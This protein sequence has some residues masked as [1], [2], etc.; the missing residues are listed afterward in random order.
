MYQKSALFFGVVILILIGVLVL[1]PAPPPEFDRAEGVKVSVGSGEVLVKNGE[2]ERRLKTGEGVLAYKSGD[3]IDLTQ[4]ENS[5][6][7]ELP[8]AIS[9]D[10]AGATA[11]DP[12]RDVT[13]PA[14][15]PGNEKLWIVGYSQT[16][17]GKPL[18]NTGIIVRVRPSDPPVKT[19]TDGQGY[20][21]V[22]VERYKRYSMMAI[23][24]EN[25]SI[26]MAAVDTGNATDAIVQNFY[27]KATVGGVRGQ[28]VDKETREPVA[29]ARIS[30][31][32]D[33][34]QRPELEKMKMGL[35]PRAI[36]DAE[37]KFEVWHLPAGNYRLE[38]EAKGY[39]YFSPKKW[40][41]DPSPLGSI[42]VSA[43]SIIED[44][45]VKLEAGGLLKV[46]V[47]DAKGQ[48]VQMARI[49]VIVDENRTT[50][51]T[52]D[53]KGEWKT[54][55]IAKGNVIV[56][57]KKDGFGESW[58]DVVKTGTVDAPAEVEIV[59]KK[60]GRVSGRVMMKDGSAGSD[61]RLILYN[62]SVQSMMGLV[63]PRQTA[64]TTTAE[65][66][67]YS[68]GDLGEGEY[69]ILV[70]P[71]I[72]GGYSRADSV[73]EKAIHLAEGQNLENVDFLIDDDLPNEKVTGIVVDQDEQPIEDVHVF[74]MVQDRQ[75]G[76]DKTGENGSDWT[77]EKGEFEISGLKKAGRIWVSAS[78]DGYKKYRE[79]IP[80]PVEPIR[81]QLTEGG[82]IEC[83]VLA[84]DTKQPV[85]HA[86]LA[87]KCY[88]DM[89]YRNK[90]GMT[91][92]DGTYTFP[93]QGK[94][95]YRIH[96][97]AKEYANTESELI[98]VEAGKDASVTIELDPTRVFQGRLVG[99]EEQP[100][101]RATI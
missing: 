71:K 14:K 30:L 6:A 34:K 51:G 4:E 58:S 101:G 76:D 60:P 92:E 94:G 3:M 77:N 11:A 32:I 31:T 100:G 21:A 43:G 37:G 42:D 86:H 38:A 24:Q 64:S 80:M 28:V 93:K 5:A 66:G 88:S 46:R 36:S 65:D 53:E 48:P 59:M 83:L 56:R 72:E 15:K 18:E 12:A 17:Q 97:Y 57:A 52:T 74:C 55:S 78:K 16:E 63:Y 68:M 87:L 82:G 95:Y 2:D 26:A 85:A 96:A 35:P 23:P 10:I 79:V 29:D 45:V 19:K 39:L 44:V 69:E 99:P 62:L 41:Y 81:I 61:Y 8:K 67:R 50:A 70:Y 91:K 22:P 13:S 75:P 20:Y 90:S 98:K 7:N 25:L 89:N 33:Y 84:K 47:V 54:D 40:N 9:Q 27:H 73:A 1:W 49:D